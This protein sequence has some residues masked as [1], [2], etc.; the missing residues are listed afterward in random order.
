MANPLTA[1]MAGE[2]SMILISEAVRSFDSGSQPGTTNSVRGRARK[3]R[4]SDVGMVTTIASRN[5]QALLRIVV[6]SRPNE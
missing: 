1:K 5:K 4:I 2:I 6:S 3:A